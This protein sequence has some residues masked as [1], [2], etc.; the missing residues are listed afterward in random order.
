VFKLFIL[1]ELD[2]QV[3]AGERRWSDVAPLSRKSLPSGMLQDWPE[4]APLT[5][6]SLAAL[7]ISQSDNSASDTL[8]HLLGREKV[9]ALLPALGLRNPAANR[10]FL[11]TLEAFALKGDDDVLTR[12]WLATDEAGRRKLWPTSARFPGA[13]RHREAAGQAE[14]HRQGSSGSP[15][16]RISSARSTGS[17]GTPAR[18][19]STSSRSIPACPAPPPS[20]SPTGAT[21]AARKPAWSR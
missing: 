15:R 19:R 21:R 3:R 9:E 2:R 11:S 12:R 7:M 13:D 14:S 5:L 8:L 20:P 17:A 18:R 16:P 4:G 10:P 1:A 6:H